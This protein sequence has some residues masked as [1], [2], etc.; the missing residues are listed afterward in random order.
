MATKGIY[1]GKHATT[2][3]SRTYKPRE[4]FECD[5][6]ELQRLCAQ[7]GGFTTYN[8]EVHDAA[9]PADEAPAGEQPST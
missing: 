3:G 7:H 1:V 9:N 6:A 4:V 2:I 5:A 8:P